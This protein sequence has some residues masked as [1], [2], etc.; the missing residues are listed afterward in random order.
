MSDLS[1]EAF[2][3]ALEAAWEHVQRVREET[4][5]VV[6]LRLTTVGL[7]ALAVDMPCNRMATVSWREL[8]RSED[9]PGLLFARISDVAQGQRRARR[10]GPVPLASAA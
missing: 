6:E 3:G 9:L 10:T 1:Q 4:G 2:A 8:A 5:V 7:T